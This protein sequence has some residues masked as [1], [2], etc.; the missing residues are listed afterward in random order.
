MAQRGDQEDD[1][2]IPLK[3]RFF[4]HKI[5]KEPRVFS[6]AEAW[7]DMVQMARFEHSKTSGFIDNRLTEWGR[8]QIPASQRYLAER[9]K[10]SKHK[11][12]NFINLLKEEK[13]ISSHNSAGNTVLTLLNYNKHNRDQQK[14][15]QKNNQNPLPADFSNEQPGS[16]RTSE[17]TSE[18]P[19]RDQRGTKYNKVNKENK[20]KVGAEAPK[21]PTDDELKFKD[22]ENWIHKYAANVGRMKEPFTID[23]WIQLRKKID[24]ATLTALLLKMHNWK[25]LNKKNVSAYLT[26]L[27]WSRKDH[28]QLNGHNG[29][30]T[31]QGA[32]IAAAIREIEGTP[33]I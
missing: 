9:W 1:G 19:A 30:P 10:W 23:Q 28:N 2:Y 33:K 16:E 32:K 13:M 29:H 25:E 20:E 15:H 7:I 5:W 4:K 18:G 24:K 12:L 14:D 3:R 26:I 11:V 17:R 6:R 22:F 21:P 27:N 8:G 31:E